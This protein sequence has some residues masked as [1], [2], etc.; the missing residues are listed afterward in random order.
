MTRIRAVLQTVAVAATLVSIG[1][2]STSKATSESLNSPEPLHEAMQQLTNTMVYDIFS[3]PQSS[4]VYSYASIAAYEA[5]RQGD[6]TW[7]SLAGQVR[8]MP[9]VPQP[10]RSKEYSFALAGVRA[11]LTVSHQL[12]FSRER[13]DSVR[14][15]MSERYKASLSS[16]VYDRSVAYGDT[17]ARHVLAWAGKDRF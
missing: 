9:A 4:R 13:M 10:D 15:A 3:P 8:N 2:Q 7:R 11:F 14:S 16:D 1:C 12:T 6:T 5:V 17:I